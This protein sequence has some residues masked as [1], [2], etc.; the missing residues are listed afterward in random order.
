M[1][2]TF[3][4]S[5]LSSKVSWR[6]REKM[7]KNAFWLVQSC[8]RIMIISKFVS[9]PILSPTVLTTCSSYTQWVH[10]K[11][12]VIIMGK[13]ETIEHGRKRVTQLCL[14][15]CDPTEAHQASPSMEFSRQEYWTGL[16]FLP[17]GDLPDPGTEPGLLHCRQTL[18]QLTHQ[19]SPFSRKRKPV[20][21]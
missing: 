3:C 21:C 15:L 20:F 17:L 8:N 19:G 13:H 2:P 6:L 16:P 10:I 7:K 12:W 11:M 18:Y 4:Q 5:T 9:I 14:T 1:W